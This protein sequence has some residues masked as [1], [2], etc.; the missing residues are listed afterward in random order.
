[1]VDWRDPAGPMWF[2]QEGAVAQQGIMLT[3]WLDRWVRL[4][5]LPEPGARGW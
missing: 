2:N 5:T 4:A 1:M 3:E